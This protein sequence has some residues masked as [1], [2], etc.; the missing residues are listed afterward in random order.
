MFFCM[1]NIIGNGELWIMCRRITRRKIRVSPIIWWT[2]VY[3]DVERVLSFKI[4]GMLLE[5][6][7]YTSPGL[8]LANQARVLEKEKKRQAIYRE[9]AK[10]RRYQHYLKTI[11]AHRLVLHALYRYVYIY[12]LLMWPII[13]S[14]L[15]AELHAWGAADVVAGACWSTLWEIDLL[16]P[17][18]WTWP[19]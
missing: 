17:K 2:I 1:C 4:G 8:L 15:T 19:Q 6:Q 11:V 14:G 18:A 16:G 7:A 5:A 10:R 3:S 13:P 9:E 12:A